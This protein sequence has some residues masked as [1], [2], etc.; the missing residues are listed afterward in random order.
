[1]EL[2]V[3]AWR[4]YYHLSFSALARVEV[5]FYSI[6]A[7]PRASVRREREACDWEVGE[8]D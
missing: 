6:I 5:L 1:V 4:P 2:K 8:E 7:A 3:G